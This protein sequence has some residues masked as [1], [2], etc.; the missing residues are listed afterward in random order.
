MSLSPENQDRLTEWQRG[1]V[2]IGDVLQGKGSSSWDQA[3]AAY[4]D[5]LAELFPAPEGLSFAEVNMGGV[6]A[7]L[8]TPE[9]VEGERVLFY[10]HG[11]GYVSGGPKAYHGLA[12]RYAKLLR[13][14]VY[15]PDYRLAPQ[16]RFPV[17]IDDT[18]TAYRSLIEEGHDPRWIAISGDSAG[19]AM[20]VTIMRKARDA[21]VPLPVAGV[22]ISPWANLSHTG[23]SINNRN[24]L[25]PLCSAE[26]LTLLA[27]NVLGD[28]LTTDPDA[29]PIFAD[30][31][32]LSPTLVQVGENEVMLSDAIRLAS[33][34][35]ENR[36]RVS[37]E[38]WPGMFHAW[39][40]FAGVM[41]EADQ[42]LRNAVAFLETAFASAQG[43]TRR[44]ASSM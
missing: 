42:A 1:A 3:R 38:V 4:I 18:F 44:I 28:V 32:G 26:F 16:Y 24:G 43:S 35:G 19:G 14:K 30:V 20:V 29:S 21:G 15:I 40:M 33:H 37:L 25:D 9:Q 36:V 39:H 22:A 2:G 31:R 6:P 27:R 13:A 17:P 11:G 10:I 7:T 34:L 12:G 41:P 23:A 8:V 5:A